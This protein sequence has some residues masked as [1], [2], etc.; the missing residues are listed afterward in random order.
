MKLPD[1]GFWRGK[2]VFV[3]GHT[4]FKGSWL[5]AW[6][7]ELGARAFGY[8]LPPITDPAL[9]ESARLAEHCEVDTRGDVRDAGRLEES[10]E[11]AAA[12]VVFHLAAQALVRTS[13]AQPRETFETNV[14]GT[15]NVLEAVR[16]RGRP[17]AVVIVT[18]DKVYADQEQGRAYRESDALGGRDPYSASKAAAEIV[19]ASYR[20]SYFPPQRLDDHGISL[21]TV[22]AGNVI[23]GGD[24][25]VDRIL[26]DAVRS[27]VA[28]T[29]LP[30]RNPASIRPWQHVLDP[31][32]GYLI[33]AREMIENPS[34]K[35]CGAWNFGPSQETEMSV[36]ALAAKFAEAWGGGSTI[37]ASNRDAPVETKTLRVNI[38]KAL[39]ELPWRPV[40]NVEEAV[41]RTARWY[42]RFYDSPQESAL[43]HCL[44]DLRDYSRLAE[45]STIP[46]T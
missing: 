6:L 3:T 20:G 31:L 42:R 2:R 15:L 45:E 21:A 22:R 36:G 46:Q 41:R 39:S 38:D 18:S 12:D 29:E 34:P 17:C 23:G 9:F 35:W 11:N 5:V 43:Q 4:G 24:W 8:S 44:T 33:L 25:S 30:L 13:Y 7:H 19:A 10:L 14:G 16:R 1:P 32:A 27:F 28:G 40:W 37:D 26:A